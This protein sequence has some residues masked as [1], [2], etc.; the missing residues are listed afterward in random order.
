[1][2]GRARAAKCCETRLLLYLQS[3]NCGNILPHGKNGTGDRVARKSVEKT[4]TDKRGKFAP[5]NP[6]KPK[7]AR[8]K[9]TRAVEELLNGQAEAISQKAV[10]MAL[11]GDST[12]LRLCLER[13]A[14][15]RK[16]VT[17]SFDLPRMECAQDAA[18][19]AQAVLWAVSEATLTPLEGASVMALIEAYRKTLE[20]SELERRVAELENAK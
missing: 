10:D 2:Q 18:G 8:H 14:P 4:Y 12:A 1:M 20:T 16:D 9:V 6:G 15:P 11:E 5:G 7:G 19:A 3:R 17:V 13:L